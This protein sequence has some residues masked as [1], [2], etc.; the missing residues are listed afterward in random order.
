MEIL[1]AIAAALGSRI[2]VVNFPACP[3]FQVA[4]VATDDPSAAVKALPST[5]LEN[6]LQI[7]IAP[8]HSQ[9]YLLPVGRLL[10]GQSL[11]FLLSKFGDSLWWF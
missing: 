6:V 1:H 8:T 10:A 9:R 3:G 5:L 2:P 11:T 4:I 7:L